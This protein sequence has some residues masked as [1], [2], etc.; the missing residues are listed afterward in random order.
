M[1]IVILVAS[2]IGILASVL[3]ANSI[4][5]ALMRII[6]GMS[7]ASEEVASASE[8]LSSASQSLSEGAS[9]QA[10]AI[11]QT[12]ASLHEMASMTSRNSESA[13]QSKTIMRE[14]RQI[15]DRVNGHMNS[16]EEAIAHI[17]TSSGETVKIVKTID[18]IAFQTNLLALNAAVEAARAGEA[19]AG[20]AVV[21]DEVRNLAMRAAE[22]AKS[23][24]NLIENTIKAVKDGSGLMDLTRNAFRENVENAEKLDGLLGEIAAATEEQSKG[25]EQIS[26]AV[27]DMEK[28]T[29][30]NAAQAEETASAS[31]EMNAQAEKMTDL[32]GGLVTLIGANG[33]GTSK[34]P[35]FA[36][37]RG[38]S[39]RL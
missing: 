2:L 5:K 30:W 18:A 11:E 4:S 23:T 34:K 12:S 31:E 3:T 19:G 8:Q 38:G 37:T 35:P 13:V 27:V 16:M 20:F 6:A 9:K 26:I 10:A 36:A 15:V 14:T 7:A 33:N 22:A 28:I 25:I 21:A 32:V 39:Q 29:Q 17:S 1:L 24:T